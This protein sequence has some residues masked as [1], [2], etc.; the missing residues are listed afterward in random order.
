[1]RSNLIIYSGYW[2]IGLATTLLCPPFYL[3]LGMNINQPVWGWVISGFLLYTSATL[4]IG[5][6][7]VNKYGSLIVYEALLR[8]IASALLIP[9]GLL[10]DYGAVTAFVGFTDALWGIVYLKTVPAITE[11]NFSQLLLDKAE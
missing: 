3:F 1:M 11:R 4:I 10:Y 6:R 9:A 2:N 5:G 7:D 8:F